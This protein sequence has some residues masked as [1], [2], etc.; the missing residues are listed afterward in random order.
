MISQ[1][2][3]AIEL[4]KALSMKM[5]MNSCRRPTHMTAMTRA[6][7]APTARDSVGRD[8]VRDLARFVA[9]TRELSVDAQ[10]ASRRSPSA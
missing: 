4:I 9:E 7:P 3:G 5:S 6:A 8:D 2:R 10:I 1:D